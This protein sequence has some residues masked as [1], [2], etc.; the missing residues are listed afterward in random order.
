MKLSG[1]AVAGNTLLFSLGTASAAVADP[2]PEA[3]QA[4]VPASPGFQPPF[5]CGQTWNSSSTN[6]A[7]HQSNEIDFNRGS[8]ADADLGDSVVAAASGT[9][10]APANQGSANGF[11]N[12]VQIDHGGGHATD[13]A[14]LNSLSPSEHC[15]S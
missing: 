5:P 11:G 15:G 6:S 4:Q 13:Y 9:V 8:A 10:A 1:L 14:H 2:T 3:E 7:A 12:L